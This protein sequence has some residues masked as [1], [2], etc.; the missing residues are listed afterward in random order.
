MFDRLVRLAPPGVVIGSVASQVFR[1]L[2]LVWAGRFVSV[3]LGADGILAMGVLQN[4]LVLGIALPAQALQMPIQQAAAGTDGKG[5]E[6]FLL[7]QILAFLSSLVVVSLVLFGRIW[8]PAGL[9][10]I[11]WILPL[12]IFLTTATSNIQAWTVGRGGLGRTNLLTAILSPLQAVWLLAWIA[13]GRT[14]LVPGIL[15]FGLIGFPVTAWRLGIPS[16]RPVRKLL[17]NLSGWWPLL[18][19]ASITTILGPGAQMILRELVL[20][21]GIHAGAVWQSAVRLS[22]ILFG[23][24]A[25]AFT[26]WALPRLAG[27]D[28]DSSGSW[29]SGVGGILLALIVL[30][31]APWLL[32]LAYAHRFQDA[33]GV[34]RVQALAEILRAVGL[35]WTLRL[36]ARRAVLS[37]SL[38]EAGATLFQLGLASILIPRLGPV[39]ASTAVLVEA[40]VTALVTWRL[41]RRLESRERS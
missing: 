24:W 18:A 37:F 30:L 23:T 17:S 28:R 6:G 7:G 26:S 16:L 25:M 36:M 32:S 4:L 13:T 11:V 33:T 8:V 20:R 29:Y 35:P 5:G 27:R 38:L 15:L 3:R 14:G 40:G 10:A 1:L 21:D 9:P 2:L 31:T 12:G 22:D 41:V 34:L 39:G 19:M